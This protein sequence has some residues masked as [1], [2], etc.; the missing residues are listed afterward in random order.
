MN[1]LVINYVKEIVQ[2]GQ[3]LRLDD[4]DFR[5]EIQDRYMTELYGAE[6]LDI[7]W[8]DARRME[9]EGRVN[10]R[11]PSRL[12]S[13]STQLAQQLVEDATA[14]LEAAAGQQ[15]EIEVAKARGPARAKVVP[16]TKAPPGEAPEPPAFWASGETAEAPPSAGG[17]STSGAKAAAA[18]RPPVSE[19]PATSRSRSPPVAKKSG[20]AAKMEPKPPAIAPHLS[21]QFDPAF[22]GAKAR[23]QT[24]RA[25]RPT[26]S[27]ITRP[28][29]APAPAAA[30][31]PIGKAKAPPPRPSSVSPAKRPSPSK[32]IGAAAPPIPPLSLPPAAVPT[33][34]AALQTSKAMTTTASKP[35][36]MS[37][38]GGVRARGSVLAE[39]A[40]G[41]RPEE[42]LPGSGPKVT[43][44]LRPRPSSAS[45][46]SSPGG[47]SSASS[48]AFGA[49][50]RAKQREEQ[51]PAA[52][53]DSSPEEEVTFPR[54]RG[55][56]GKRR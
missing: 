10:V 34:P 24:P 49:R 15:Q 14:R 54:G 47:A 45:P 21:K 31:L 20:S 48:P 30:A 36:T 35:S 38:S 12:Q 17:Q 27:P 19:G 5:K 46:R 40:P 18:V 44:P 29:A 33:D 4:P 42:L 37:V 43:P 8:E 25:A 51:P 39:P 16:P 11:L 22:G 3:Q 2:N 50:A 1:A 9:E 32:A 6:N 26:T 41:L 53:R 56:G 13:R 7:S 28:P 23:S 52:E 55:K